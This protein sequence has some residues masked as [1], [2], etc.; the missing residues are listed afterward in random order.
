M[1]GDFWQVR[2]S[3]NL[4]TVNIISLYYSGT[5]NYDESFSEAVL[6]SLDFD[7]YS[8]DP[9]KEVDWRCIDG[10]AQKIAEGM[11]AKLKQGDVKFN[12][13]VTKIKRDWKTKGQDKM[14]IR[15][16]P[17]MDNEKDEDRRHYAAV[18]CSTTL[19]CMQRMDLTSA[20]INYGAKLA[21]RALR[22]GVSCKIGI[23][24]S[25]AWWIEDL[26]IRGGVAS[27]DLPLRMCVYPSYNIEDY[28]KNHD[29]EAVLLCSYTW[30][31][32]AQ[33]LTALISKGTPE[34]KEE[35]KEIM[36]QNLALLHSKQ[37][38][39][40]KHTPTYQDLYQKIKKLYITHH[41]YDW[42]DD[43]DMSGA[44]AHFGPGQFSKMYP[45]LIQPQGG[46]RLFIIGEAASKHHAWVVG[47][48]ESAIRGIYQLLQEYQRVNKTA[49][50]KAMEILEDKKNSPYGPVPYEENR[51]V[52]AQQVAISKS[53]EEGKRD[54]PR[55]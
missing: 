16:G 37:Q 7:Y 9:K 50:L 21:I 31:Q 30:G 26:G 27:T 34:A 22:Y 15:V 53:R 49:A 32:D 20:V 51:D 33:R 28:D 54:V 17:A 11:R 14:I 5:L 2:S 13:R 23:K 47:A 1:D 44:F 39:G 52:V 35:L 55:E 19:A 12:S 38:R 48:L 40:H 29:T 24:F 36:F 46:G 25:K 6:G 42:G 43:K 41:A 10:G 8:N 4:A 18:F 3:Q 45:D